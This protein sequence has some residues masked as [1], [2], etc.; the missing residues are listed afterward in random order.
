LL[1]LYIVSHLGE[2]QGEPL[3]DHGAQPLAL[4]IPSTRLEIVIDSRL[5]NSI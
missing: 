2:G 1:L 3:P 5:S 4:N